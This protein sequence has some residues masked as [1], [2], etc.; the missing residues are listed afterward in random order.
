MSSTSDRDR[1]PGGNGSR[2]HTDDDA[3]PASLVEGTRALVRWFGL[4]SFGTA[5]T[6]LVVGIAASL[7]AAFVVRVNLVSSATNH[8]ANSATTANSAMTST[9]RRYGDLSAATASFIGSSIPNDYAGD[10]KEFIGY[11][12]TLGLAQR[13][14]GTYGLGFMARIPAGDAPALD[15]QMKADGEPGFVLNSSPRPYACPIEFLQWLAPGVFPTDY[16][17]MDYCAGNL[18]QGQMDQTIA[19]GRQSVIP[20]VTFVP[21]PGHGSDFATFTPVFDPGKP[22]ATPEQRAQSL[23]GWVVGLFQGQT[24]ARAAAPRANDIGVKLYAGGRTPA[25]LIVTEPTAQPNGADARDFHITAD[26]PWTFQVVDMGPGAGAM[27]IIAPVG[28]LVG[29]VALSVALFFL[30]QM[31]RHAEGRARELADEATA[32][33]RD[34]EERF[35]SLAASSPAGILQVEPKG[36]CLYANDRMGEIV[37]RSPQSLTGRGWLEAIPARDRQAFLDRVRPALHAREVISA[38]T[39]I[40]TPDGEMRWARVRTAPHTSAGGSVVSYVVTVED[41]TRL[42]ESSERLEEQALHDSLTGL[43]NRTLFLDRLGHALERMRSRGTPLAV[44]FLDL[45]RFKV[46]NDSLGHYQGDKLLIAVAKRIGTSL[47]KGDTLA[48]FGGDE[49]TIL[50]EG[51]GSAEDGAHLAER[52]SDALRQPFALGASETFVTVSTGI[53]I[54]TESRADP[55]SILTDA[56]AA[57]YLAK[58]RGRARYEIF[59]TELREDARRRLSLEAALRRALERH[60]LRTFYQP[61]IDVFT[62][63]L[64]GAEALIRWEHPDRGILAPQ[65]FIALAEETGLIIPIGSWVLEDALQQYAWWRRTLPP[66]SQMHQIAVNLSSRQLAQVGLAAEVSSALSSAAVEP[67]EL[68]LEVTESALMNESPHVV[69]TVRELKELG[70]KLAID[71]FG[72]GFSSFSRLKGLPVDVL[73]IDRSFVDGLGKDSDDEAIVETVIKLGHLLGLTIVAEGVETQAQLM[74]LRRRGAEQAQGFLW[75]RPL[76]PAEFVRWCKTRASRT[77][78]GGRRPSSTSV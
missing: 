24:I 48:R 35:R 63:E 45:D 62:E 54:V 75:S 70:V 19:T 47:R 8:F 31:L 26:G 22:A 64:R 44:L 53:V 56:D 39:R 11:V 51:I 23:T 13:Y 18:I 10:R 20:R 65:E 14:P 66:K 12:N 49:F 61:Q 50:A 30:I 28:T 6:V 55:Q 59:N 7:A 69:H 68:Y 1:H 52:V 17:T 73:K 72:T 74:A 5:L 57:M 25:N 29:G 4:L 33:L 76:P 77:A 38:D 60:E 21:G 40:Q 34:S 2:D 46:V 78:R 32:S 67:S 42:V 58:E 3:A 27:G 15:A 71:D 36:N 43:A 9:L 41:I 16:A 37:G